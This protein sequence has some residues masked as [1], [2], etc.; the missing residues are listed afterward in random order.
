MKTKTHNR[1]KRFTA[2]RNACKLCAPL[3]A[4]VVLR[5]I[6]GS[7]PFLHG[8]QG[9][10]TYIR[11]YMISHFREPV[12]IA[13]SSFSEET[14]IFGG[15]ENLKSGLHNVYT[16]YKPKL[17]GVAST[18]LAETIGD[19]VSMFLRELRT[20]QV[21]PEGVKIVN[22]ST[23]SFKETHMDGYY[24][25]VRGV[26]SGMCNGIPL[27]SA[28]INVFPSFLSCEDLRY[29]KEIL[30]DFGL[31]YVMLPDYSDTL[32]GAAWGEYKKIPEGGTKVSEIE[33]MGGSA[34]SIEFSS[35]IADEQSAAKFLEDRFGVPYFNLTIPIGI[36]QTDIFFGL[37][38]NITGSPIPEKY[39]AERGRLVDSYVD[40]H[41]YLF[42]KKAVIYGEEDMVI[43][44]A[45]FLREIGLDP[46]LCISGGN[47]GRIKD[48]LGAVLGDGA[49]NIEIRDD[50][51]FMDMEDEV[52]SLK[53]DILIGNSKGYSVARLF[54]TPLVRTFFPIHDRI[55]SQRILHIGYRGTQN[56]FDR[57][58]NALLSKKQ[59]D[60]DVGYS[61]L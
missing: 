28:N 51:D 17:I 11:R 30:R 32:D 7:V 38:E 54:N 41:K 1:K 8:S 20:E 6:E 33:S 37:L 19:D 46:V 39:I 13:S 58:V 31:K 45:S 9:C 22:V 23:P 48:A 56:L 27:K 24:S 16:Q 59:E 47:S 42:G 21:I 14:A 34:V 4:C 57:I 12:D 25:A 18:C 44:T 2:T 5:G 35:T 50:A 49:K 26:V 61:Y 53:P 43:A 55:G 60:S 40:A 3:G 15:K 10:A 52:R 36:R 29:L